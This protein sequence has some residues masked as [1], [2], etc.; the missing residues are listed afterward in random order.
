MSGER[1]CPTGQPITQ[2]ACCAGISC[3]SATLIIS[4]GAAAIDRGRGALDV[5]RL[6]RTE[7]QRERCNILDPPDPAYAALCQC[8]RPQLLDRLAGRGCA[9]RQQ[10][11]LTLGRGIAR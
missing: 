6:L 7:E 5:A 1:E 2:A 8:R 4:N 9:L 10:F 3:S 11:L